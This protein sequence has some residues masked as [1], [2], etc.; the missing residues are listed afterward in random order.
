MSV[1]AP[2]HLVLSDKELVVVLLIALI[3]TYTILDGL[4]ILLKFILRVVLLVREKFLFFFTGVEPRLVQLGVM[5]LRDHHEFSCRAR[6]V[7]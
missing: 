1:V 7:I 5:M 6:E 4:D 2:D 3:V